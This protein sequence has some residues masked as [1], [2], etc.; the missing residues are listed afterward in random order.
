MPMI[1]WVLM[2]RMAATS[3]TPFALK[4]AAPPALAARAIADMKTGP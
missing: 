2:A 1:G 3:W 4:P